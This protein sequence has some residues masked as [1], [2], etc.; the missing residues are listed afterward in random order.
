M[1]FST[2]P[3]NNGHQMYF[4]F[5]WLRKLLVRQMAIQML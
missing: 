4:R 5:K 3:V 2:E 1:P